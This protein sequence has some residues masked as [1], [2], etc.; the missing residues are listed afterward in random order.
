MLS[1]FT[2][3]INKVKKL[4]HFFNFYWY[5]FQTALVINFHKDILNPKQKHNQKLR[6]TLR[7]LRLK[8]QQR[9]SKMPRKHKST[10]SHKKKKVF[11]D[12]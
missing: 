10:K 4:S 12:P 5:Y 11:N 1:K 8:E 6:G 3:Y 2:Q 7:T 9:H